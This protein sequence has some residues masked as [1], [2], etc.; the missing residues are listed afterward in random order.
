MNGR[1]GGFRVWC[2]LGSSVIQGL[3]RGQLAV[4]I[5]LSTCF[6]LSLGRSRR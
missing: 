4:L 6:A 3:V 5:R 1:G 2:D